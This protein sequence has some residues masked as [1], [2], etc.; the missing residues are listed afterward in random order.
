MNK[1]SELV[2]SLG[3]DRARI[4]FAQCG[5]LSNELL[6]AADCLGHVP[7]MILAFNCEPSVPFRLTRASA[8]YRS[9]TVQTPFR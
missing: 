2:A 5:G 8:G 4:V 6:L 3:S 7:L 9:D 1:I